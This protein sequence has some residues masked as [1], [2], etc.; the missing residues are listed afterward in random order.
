MQLLTLASHLTTAPPISLASLLLPLAAASYL[1]ARGQGSAAV[2][3]DE[4]EFGAV[5][6]GV[7]L[8]TCAGED[9]AY[10]IQCWADCPVQQWIVG[11]IC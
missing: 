4:N 11:S 2:H 3:R 9:R 5:P 10:A 8:G 1:N 6:K 7:E